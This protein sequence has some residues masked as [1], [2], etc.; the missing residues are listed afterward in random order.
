MKSCVDSKLNPFKKNSQ[1]L[2]IIN[3]SVVLISPVRT[4]I[5]SSFS[6]EKSLILLRK[7]KLL[8]YSISLFMLL[9]YVKTETVR[10]ASLSDFM[11]I[12]LLFDIG[13][14]VLFVS[15]PS[16]WIFPLSI[17]R[18][19]YVSVKVFASMSR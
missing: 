15:F 10:F 4:R 3:V 14:K 17:E 7:L 16:I 18:P 2:L 19:M 5:K 6:L 9:L 12:G 11:V 1:G 8:V 13:T